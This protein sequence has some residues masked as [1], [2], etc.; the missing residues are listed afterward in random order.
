LDP[1]PSS[2][3]STGDTFGILVSKILAIVLP[4]AGVTALVIMLKKKPKRQ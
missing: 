3:G 2:P 4:F 1:F